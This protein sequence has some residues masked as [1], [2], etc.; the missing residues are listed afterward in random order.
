MEIYVV[1]VTKECNCDCLYCYEQDKT[2]QYTW[3]EIKELIDKIIENRTSD[4]F[5][6]EFLGGEPMLR[7]N[8]IKK[9]Y[10]HLE[11]IKG[12]NVIDYVITT[13]G[14]IINEEIANYLSKNKKIKFAVSM[15]GHKW[16][17]QLRVFKDSRKNTYDKVMGNIKYLKKYG[18]ESSIH[19]VTH[20]YNVAF[21]SESI[22]HLYKQGIKFIDVG[23][24]ESSITID[25]DYCDRFVYELG[26]VSEKIADGV[27]SDLHIGLFKWLKPYSDV[28]SYIKDPI[29]GKTIAESYGRSGKDITNT[30]DYEVV[31]CTNKDEISELIYYIRKKVYNNHQIKLKGVKSNDN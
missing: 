21:I 20:P 9:S 17:N 29:T 26:I 28:R 11:G 1:H 31:R 8:L 14:T 24:V 15:D 13:N 12:I 2:S 4:E 7:W 27:Y 25:K 18:V 6:I 22:D 30:N 3:E 10:E 19:M 16:A 23:T 5:G